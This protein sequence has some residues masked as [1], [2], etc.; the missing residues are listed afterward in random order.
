MFFY[1]N[2]GFKNST[3]LLLSRRKHFI[4][5]K[6]LITRRYLGV[7]TG[8]KSNHVIFLNF[9][10]PIKWE[11]PFGIVKIKWSNIHMKFFQV[12]GER[13]AYCGCFTLNSLM[14]DLLERE[15]ADPQKW[16]PLLPPLIPS[17]TISTSFSVSVSIAFFC[18]IY[19]FL[20]F[21]I[22]LDCLMAPAF[23]FLGTYAF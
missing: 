16:E 12:A 5:S 9:V 14:L 23:C 17:V 11:E 10:S 20:S 13:N 21:P 22:S 2:V 8:S 18:L 15:A 1:L 6:H 19:D 3:L 4:G 7:F